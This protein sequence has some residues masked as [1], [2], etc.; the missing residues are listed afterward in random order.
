MGPPFFISPH[1][2]CDIVT[3]VLAYSVTSAR[4]TRRMAFLGPLITELGLAAVEGAVGETGLG[5]A[6]A[7]TAAEVGGLYEAG[8]QLHDYGH[9][10]HDAY[11]KTKEY[12]DKMATAIKNA[13]DRKKGKQKTQSDSNMLRIGQAKRTRDEM[14]AAAPGSGETRAGTRYR[15]HG[16]TPGGVPSEPTSQSN[17]MSTKRGAT[18]G[19]EVAIIPPPKR[20]SKIT[21]DYFTINLPYYESFTYD[22]TGIQMASTNSNVI[23]I[24]MNSIYD[25]II[26]SKSNRQPQGRDQW[27]GVFQYY[28]VMKSHITVKWTNSNPI[29][30]T[31]QVYD[32]VSSTKFLPD[33]MAGNFTV[34]YE[35]TNGVSDTISPNHDQFIMCKHAKRVT[36]PA[37]PVAAMYNGTNTVVYPQTLTHA[38]ISYTY[39]PEDWDYH[40]QNTST[41]E[42]WTP[43]KQN[44]TNDHLMALRV[45]QQVST[46]TPKDSSIF[47]QVHINFTV[48]FREAS[49]AL[50]K[51]IDSTG[52][53]YGGTGED[54]TDTV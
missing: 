23:N 12:A 16:P 8:K 17:S 44:P 6:V 51:G 11:V 47:V 13:A 39:T 31:P 25:P 22:A 36:L 19:D 40:V 38:S 9:K 28:R 29:R 27:A 48:Q 50:I 32:A 15:V 35:L 4:V 2:V 7:A 24:R 1:C 53:S 54:P 41:E 34:G 30:P 43:I 3:F 26:G 33:M 42:R 52:A 46:Y 21:P 14:E 49:Q 5:T 37:C 45:F 20:I 18:D 10:A